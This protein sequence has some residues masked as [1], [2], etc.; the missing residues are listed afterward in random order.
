MPMRSTSYG[1]PP[2]EI[3]GDSGMSIAFNLAPISDVERAQR[4]ASILREAGGP[5]AS[6]VL[7]LPHT[8]PGAIMP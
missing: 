1:R 4:M 3:T 6:E 7:Q 8:K 2:Q 5:G